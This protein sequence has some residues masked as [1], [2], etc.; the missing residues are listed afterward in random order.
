MQGQ[1]HSKEGAEQR[2]PWPQHLE[3]IVFHAS[4]HHGFLS[5]LRTTKQ[6][7]SRV[8]P[9]PPHSLKD[10]A[11]S[12]VWVPEGP[13]VWGGQLIADLGPGASGAFEAWVR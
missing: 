10:R 9:F 4:E 8:L 2:E 7:G 5:P 3:A 6:T 12:P 11:L 1:I 13:Q